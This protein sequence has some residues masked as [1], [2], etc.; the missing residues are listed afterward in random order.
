VLCPS[1]YVRTG[2]ER[3]DTAARFRAG[4]AGGF[5]KTPALLGFDNPRV[6]GRTFGEAAELVHEKLPHSL[7]VFRNF[8]RSLQFFVIGELC[9]DRCVSFFH[10]I[11]VQ[12]AFWGNSVDFLGQDRQVFTGARP[13]QSCRQ[14]QSD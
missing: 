6:E 12:H 4:T 3:P 14:T 1:R 10:Q 2:R 5:Q 8:L 9:I 7:L 13:Q 11:R